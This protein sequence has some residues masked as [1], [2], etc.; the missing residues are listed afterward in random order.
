MEGCTL[1]IHLPPYRSL[2]LRRDFHQGYDTS[3]CISKGHG[4]QIINFARRHNNHGKLSRVCNATH[5]L[6]NPSVNLL[7]VC[8]KLAKVHSHPF[9]GVAIPGLQSKL[10]SNEIFLAKRKAFKSKT[11]CYRNHVP[12]FQVPSASRV[13]NFLD[14]CQSTMPT[15]LETPLHIRALQMDLINAI[16]PLG[17]HASY[18]IKATLSQEAINDLQWWIDSAHLNNGRDIIPPPENTMIFCNASKIGW[19]VHLDSILIGARWFKKK[20]SFHMNFLEIKAAF[21][22]FQALVPSVK[23]SHICFGIDNCIAMSHINKLGDTHSQNLSNLAI[24]LWNYAL[25]RNL[26]ISAIHIPG[27]LNVLADHKS[28]IFNDSI[29]WMLNP[30]IFRGVVARLGQPDIDLFALRVNHQIPEFISW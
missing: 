30:R 22:A 13:A 5:R 3:D 2:F 10:I 7:G 20:A 19:G 28:R 1:P 15:I 8:D 26:I 6:G 29:E 27:K 14:L 21:L 18:K 4:D 17:P 9:K 12:S 24:E 11:V 16:A 23:G 25:N